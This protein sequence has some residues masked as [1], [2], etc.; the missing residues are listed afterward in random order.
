MGLLGTQSWTL[1]VF[2]CWMCV[3]L[4][5]A[6]PHYMVAIP[7][8]LEAGAETRFCASLLQPSETLVMT[9]SLKNQENNTIL[10]E[11]TSSEEFHECIL[12]QVPLVKTEEV[13]TLEV[14]VRGDTFHSKEV[15]KI[16]IKVY[17]PGMFVQ[18]DKPIYIPGQTVHFRVVTLDFKFR[19]VSQLYDVITLEDPYKNRIG[20]WLNESSNSKILQLSY[21]LSSEARQGI[22]RIIV[23]VGE[24]E[25]YHDFKVEK[26]VLPKFDVTLTVKEKLSIRE[27]EF[28]VKVC[29]K[30]T[31]GQ[32]VPSTVI[33]KVCRPPGI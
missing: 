17:K 7:A 4:A 23:S 2:L 3:N 1:C 12:F 21:D 33:V 31:Y 15:R 28:D 30:Y 11:K 27:E 13:R 14:F 24:D 22:Y 10:L 25:L 26:Y 20:L 18:T 8:V 5:S 6:E 9:V 16:M 32:P 19:P 29:A